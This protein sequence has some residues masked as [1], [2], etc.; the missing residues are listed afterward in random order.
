M[1][2]LFQ[3]EDN[4]E[5]LKPEPFY[6]KYLM[7]CKCFYL[8]QFLNSVAAVIGCGLYRSKPTLFITVKIIIWPF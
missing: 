5:R 2:R 8:L 7:V 6:S 3:N 4:L 1:K